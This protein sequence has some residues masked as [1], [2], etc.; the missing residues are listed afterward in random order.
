[1]L[2]IKGVPPATPRPTDEEVLHQAYLDR[3]EELRR[4]DLIFIYALEEN[5]HVVY[6]GQT[7]DPSRRLKEHQWN[8]MKKHLT[9]TILQEVEGRVAAYKAE[10]A[11]IW[12][13][14]Q[15]TT[16]LNDTY[17]H[18]G[19]GPPLSELLGIA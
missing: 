1:M 8:F 17:T 12:F 9:M 6:V 5:G 2:T 16:L 18:R 14:S 11:W 15:K 3:M 7:N 19:N 13:F 4:Q 10:E